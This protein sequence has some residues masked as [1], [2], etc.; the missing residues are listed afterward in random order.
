MKFSS[1]ARH[2]CRLTKKH[3]TILCV[4]VVLV[5]WAAYWPITRFFFNGDFGKSG[6]F[7]DT[8]GALNALFTGLAFVVVLATL[9]QQ[10]RQLEENKQDVKDDRRLRLKLDLYERR[11]R[12]YQA[13][14]DFIRNVL[15][16]SSDNISQE[17]MVSFET[18]RNEASFLFA[19]D[20]DL[21]S[22]LEQL[23][24]MSQEYVNLKSQA[25]GKGVGSE[26]SKQRDKIN[27]Q[28]YAQLRAAKDKFVQ[29]LAFRSEETPPCSFAR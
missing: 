14:V 11:F 27:D 23:R 7:G 18:A 16:L 4:S 17:Q 12:V 15:D 2:W 28:L 5:L 25:K 6:Q 29:H 9:F 21:L 10:S 1:T 24:N 8:F 20:A 22:Y 26:E 3:I 19:E 13:T